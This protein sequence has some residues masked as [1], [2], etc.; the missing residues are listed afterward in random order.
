MSKK[1]LPLAEVLGHEA[2]DKR[3]DIL[4]RIGQDGSISQA[5]RGAG[6]SYKAA[7]QALE[8]LANLAGIPLVEKAVGGS[9]GG[10][11]ALTPAGQRVLQAADELAQARQGVLARLT[12]DRDIRGTPGLAALA[13][14]TSMRNQFPCKVA[15]VTP[16]QGLMRVKLVLADDGAIYA[17]ITR[18]SAQLLGLKPGLPVLALCKA[19]AV[20]VA[21]HIVPAPTRNVLQAVVTRASRAAAGGEVGLHLPSGVQLVGF[22]QAGHGLRPGQAAMACVDEAAIVIAAAV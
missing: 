3:I 16:H 2:S 21:K 18:E 15:T 7:W 10:G 13:L 4:R 19:T 17:R 5:A 1:T 8:T 14:R 11:A 6:V 12:Q 20:Q 9:G 22:A